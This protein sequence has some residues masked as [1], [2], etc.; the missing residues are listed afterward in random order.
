MPEFKFSNLIVAIK[1]LR[2]WVVEQLI[3]VF[4]VEIAAQEAAA[5]FSRY[6]RQTFDGLCRTV[7]KVT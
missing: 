7:M 1:P 5:I 6:L 4:K 3:D 2:L